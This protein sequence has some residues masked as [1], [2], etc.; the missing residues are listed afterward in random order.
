MEK[1]SIDLFPSMTLAR[2]LEQLPARMEPKETLFNSVFTQS[3]RRIRSA[4]TL[5]NWFVHMSMTLRE[6]LFS[7]PSTKLMGGGCS[8]TV[9]R[10]TLNYKTF[11]QRKLVQCLPNVEKAIMDVCVSLYEYFIVSPFICFA[12]RGQAKKHD[13]RVKADESW[14]TLLGHGVRARYCMMHLN[15]Q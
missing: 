7:I 11:K 5:D 6:G 14:F 1:S 4:P 13:D 10:H 9:I 8:I 3:E 2:S 12:P 15:A